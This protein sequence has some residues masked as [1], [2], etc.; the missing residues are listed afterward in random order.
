MLE[1]I[2]YAEN[3]YAME[4]MRTDGVSLHIPLTFLGLPQ[5]ENYV[6]YMYLRILKELGGR[7]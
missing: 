6:Q 5:H 2:A 3:A 1:P 4:S 7:Q